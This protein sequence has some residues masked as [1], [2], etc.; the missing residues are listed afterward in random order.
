[1]ND[2]IEIFLGAK[3]Y[4]PTQCALLHVDRLLVTL[5]REGSELVYASAA[6]GSVLYGG[7]VNKA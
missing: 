3:N 1:M 7:C 2:T 5:P 4:R 6:A